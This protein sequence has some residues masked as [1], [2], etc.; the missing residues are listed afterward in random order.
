M[1]TEY[2]DR[3]IARTVKFL[4]EQGRK[5]VVCVACSGSGY[6]DSHGSPKCSSCD[7]TGKVREWVM[8][9]SSKPVVQDWREQ[10]RTKLALKAAKRK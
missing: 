10:L 4:S 3:K 9:V 5:L 2:K 1:C 7:G 6:Y 8:T